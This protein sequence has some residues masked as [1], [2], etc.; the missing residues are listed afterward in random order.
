MIQKLIL[1]FILSM[2]ISKIEAQLQNGLYFENLEGTIWTSDKP[3]T[4]SSGFISKHFG[5]VLF[6]SKIDS[7]VNNLNLWVFDS[8]N[9]YLISNQDTLLQFD[10]Q[11]DKVRKNITF[12]SKLESTTYNYCSVSTGKYIMFSTNNTIVIQGEAQNSKEGAIL[13]SDGERYIIHEMNEWKNAFLGQIVK[14]N[15]EIIHTE[16]ISEIDLGYSNNELKQGRL[17]SITTIKLK[18]KIKIVN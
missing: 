15:A 2:T 16:F 4:D 10:Y 7:I 11:I 6:N 14:V 12:K 9:L 1:I 8:T 13:Q 18:G 3:I 5:L 17:G